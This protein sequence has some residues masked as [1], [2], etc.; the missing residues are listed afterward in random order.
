MNNNKSLILNDNLWKVMIKLSL[1]AVIAMILHGLNTVFDAIFVGRFVG[2]IALSGVSVA[3][4]LTQIS[5]G[6]GSLIGGGAGAYL[7]IV[8]GENNKGAQR[9]ILGNANYMG[10]ICTLFLMVVLFIFSKPLMVFMGGEGEALALGLTYFR[11]TIFGTLFWVFG[12]AYNLIIRAEGKMGTAALIMGLGLGSNIIINY[13]LMGVFHFGVVGAAWGTNIGMFVYTLLGAIYLKS[14]KPSFEANLLS[15]S[16]DRD[17][18]SNI[19]SMGLPSLIMSI[20]SVLQGIVIL[21]SIGVVGTT[22]DLAFYGVSYRL[23][24]FMMTPLFA[25]MRSL[26]PTVGIN[27]GARQYDRVIKA[28][29]IFIV[30]ALIFIL[31]LWLF[32]MGNPQWVLSLMFK[33]VVSKEN[34]TNFRIF[35]SVIPLLA[36]TMNGMSYFP[37]INKGKI[38][39]IVAMLR[40][41]ILYIPA[42][43]FLPR[44]FGVN[45][46]YLGSFLLDA[47]LTIV[48]L[49]LLLK[50]F[51]DLKEG[52]VQMPITKKEGKI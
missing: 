38:A 36:I 37:S 17:I 8:I 45:F 18:I 31:P 34:I 49:V 21:N 42:M 14:N 28:T 33:S 2:E 9:K 44:I 23:M 46:V 7:S 40:Q 47:S 1:P 43:I 32:L 24:L 5:V 29:K 48:V 4:P 30:S 12:L 13:L 52:K 15:I 6:F 50:S 41:V 11:I 27:F 20:M 39:S 16:R 26:Q 25:I 3:Y 51:K 19:K 35:I 22:Y 10:L